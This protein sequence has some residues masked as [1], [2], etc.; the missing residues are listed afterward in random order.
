[1]SDPRAMALTRVESLIA[2]LESMV[3][4]GE[5]WNKANGGWTTQSRDTWLREFRDVRSRLE[6]GESDFDYLGH[7]LLRVLDHDGVIG[8]PIHQT[9]AELPGDLL[10]L[11]D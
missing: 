7:H 6:S 1:M 4:P 3:D 2:Q 8:G 9:A 11:S 10:A 5:D